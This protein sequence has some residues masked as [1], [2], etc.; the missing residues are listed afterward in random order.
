MVAMTMISVAIGPSLGV[1]CIPE[2]VVSGY[3]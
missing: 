3:A 1:S 2:C